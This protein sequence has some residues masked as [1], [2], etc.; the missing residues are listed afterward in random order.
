MSAQNVQREMASAA[1]GAAIAASGLRKS[2]DAGAQRVTALDGV[3]LE[4]PRGEFV[5]V[6]GP[7]GS[8]KSTL[9]HILAGLIAPDAGSVRIGETEIHALGDAEAARFRRRHVGLVFQF[10]NLIPTLDVEEN[11]ALSLLL[12]G[13]R[14]AELRGEIE[15]LAAQLGIADRLRRHPASL[16]GGEM[17]R[18]A[19][20]RALLVRP[21][22]LLAD[23]PTGNLDSRSG[24][25]VLSLLRRSCDAQGVTTLLVTHELRAC[26]YADRV[27]VLRDGR[28]TDDV[29]A[30]RFGAEP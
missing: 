2:Y 14:L 25:E 18:V 29:P 26:S 13:R 4:V 22:L 6:M 20:A 24:E 5:C 12:E 9:L 27:V 8:G 7:S 10:F 1:R 3:D 11:I 28:V 19:I 17:Q 23:E 21:A 30:D 16:S 15:A